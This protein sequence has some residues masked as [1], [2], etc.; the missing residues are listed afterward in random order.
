MNPPWMLAALLTLAVA[1]AW[2]RLLLWQRRALPASRSRGWRL[3]LLLLL[4]PLCAAL[5]YFTLLP[6]TRPGEAG[7]LTVATARADSTRFEGMA[8]GDRLIAL[9]EAPT[10]M[11]AERVPDLATALR[12]T[13]GTTQLNIIGA[14]LEPRDREAARGL[15]LRF[16][17]APLPRGVVRLDAPSVVAAG[18]TFAIGGRVEGVNGGAVELLD[19]A[20]Q[21]VHRAALP[22]SG[23]FALRGAARAPGTAMFTL[24]VRDAQRGLVED[25]AVPLSIASTPAP[26]VWLLAGAPNPELKYLRRWAADAGLSLHTQ[27]SVGGG[28]QL[29]DAPLPMNAA[30]LQRFD[31]LVLDERS[32]AALGTGERA[33][34]GEAL[35]DGLGVLLRVTGPL[36]DSTRRQLRALGFSLSSGTDTATIRLPADALDDEAQRARRGPGTRDAP[37]ALVSASA[38]N[39][40]L[41]RR[42]VRIAAADAVPLL[43]DVSGAVIASWRAEGRGRFAV[44]TLTDSFALTLSGQADRHAE[45]WSDTFAT[46]ARAQSTAMPRIDPQAREQQRMVLC[47]LAG[48]PRVLAPDGHVAALLS[49][50]ATGDS[51]CA[52]YW[53]KRPGWHLLQQ[54][55]ADAGERAWPFFVY[56]ADAA[57]ALHAAELRDATLR[58]IG[59]SR[60]A[61]ENLGGNGPLDR[62]GPSWPWFLAWLISAAA[63]WWLERARLGRASAAA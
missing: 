3:A 26:R 11:D 57:P 60:H 38:E 14:G 41:T 5:L 25:I 17:P 2:T 39:P 33:A 50:P 29:G 30:T 42:A 18:S 54:T 53:P 13:P 49:D 20:D 31:L 21:R 47:G 15:T 10:L 23:E 55:D 1:L 48:K 27:L 44:W 63:L 28:L 22:A 34:L 16:D 12:K 32:W 37:A 35:R 58:L 9:P 59:A 51:A 36:P 52:A 62:R 19:P 43:R 6:P 4:Q 40:E 46:L 24:R 61:T 45:L 8:A 56:A 7:A